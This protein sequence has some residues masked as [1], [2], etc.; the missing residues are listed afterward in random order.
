MFVGCESLKISSA[1]CL[2]RRILGLT[3][4]KEPA[5]QVLVLM[6]D[7]G[8]KAQSPVLSASW[9]ALRCGSPAEVRRPDRSVLLRLR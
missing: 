6:L 7:L 8:A 2:A 3:E 9:G 1:S 5:Q 4:K